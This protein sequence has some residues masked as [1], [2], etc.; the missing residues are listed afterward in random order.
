MTKRTE[1][2]GRV[3]AGWLGGALAKSK[4]TL[5]LSEVDVAPGKWM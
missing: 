2:S 3:T 1:W 5:K 4:A